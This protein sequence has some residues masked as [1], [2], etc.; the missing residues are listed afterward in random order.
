LRLKSTF[1][2]NTHF[3]R[4]PFFAPRTIAAG[5]SLNGS[6]TMGTGYE[7]EFI[8][9]N[10][11]T[12]RRPLGPGTV[13]LLGGFSVQTGS[14]ESSSSHAQCF[15][16]DATEWNNVS[17]GT[18]GNQAVIPYQSLLRLGAT[19]VDIGQTQ[20]VVGEVP[21]S[22]APNPNLK[23]ETKREFNAGIDAGLFNNRLTLNLDAYAS[24]TKDLLL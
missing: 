10:T 12:Y 15:P 20:E 23:W 17:Y 21:S 22:A 14:S 13:D 9:E 24:V 6:A 2:S 7:R 1:G 16:V 19:F 11:V 8:N 18:T 4:N 5:A 3:W